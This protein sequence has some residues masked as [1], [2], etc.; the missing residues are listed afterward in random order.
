MP[1]NIRLKV[2]TMFRKHTKSGTFSYIDN[3]YAENNINK[4]FLLLE[5]IP[6]VVAAI[7]TIS[8]TSMK[9]K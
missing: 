2:F 7:L 1:I 8:T 4:L 3:F 5:M 9:I 6:R